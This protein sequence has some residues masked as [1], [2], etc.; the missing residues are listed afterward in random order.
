MNGS[1]VNQQQ[2]A[3]EPVAS[4]PSKRV[5]HVGEQP[6]YAFVKKVDKNSRQLTDTLS[7]PTTTSA[8]P[9]ITMSTG[10]YVIVYPTEIEVMNSSESE[11]MS[12]SPTSVMTRS[13]SDSS[14]SDVKLVT[15]A[16]S[17]FTR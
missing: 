3:A 10:D 11:V 8:P 1:V 5:I 4:T 17:C 9:M 13:S 14:C 7:A 2:H 15:I 6:V 16:V 12:T